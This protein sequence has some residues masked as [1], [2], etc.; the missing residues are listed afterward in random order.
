MEQRLLFGTVTARKEIGKLDA[1]GSP[2][3]GNI[4]LMQHE[5]IVRCVAAEMPAVAVWTAV[6][7]FYYS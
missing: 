1:G 5:H 2:A 4:G 3:R 7:F 6:K